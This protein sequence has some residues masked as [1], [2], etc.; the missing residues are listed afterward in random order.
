M[1]I[2]QSQERKFKDQLSALTNISLERT[3]KK[4]FYIKLRKGKEPNRITE[5]ATVTSFK[6]ARIL[7]S[8]FQSQHKHTM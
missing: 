2:T 7:W 4:G 6:Q 1:I 8:E 5:F 3:T